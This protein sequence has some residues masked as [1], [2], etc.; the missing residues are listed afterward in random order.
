ML[1]KLSKFG[2]Q[3]VTNMYKDKIVSNHKIVCYGESIFITC[4]HRP[5]SAR[6]L[7]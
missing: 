5:S 1:K 3:V 6:M 7:V 2:V 4:T